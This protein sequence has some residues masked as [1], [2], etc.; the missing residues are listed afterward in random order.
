M[1]WVHGLMAAILV[2]SAGLQLND[3]DPVVWVA[4]YAAAALLAALAATGR[5]PAWRRPVALVV[6]FVALGWALS[7]AFS[8]P[9]VPPLGELVGDWR[10]Y[11]SG[12]EERRETL[13]LLWI[14]CWS[15]LVALPARRGVTRAVY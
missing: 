7:V 15:A 3:P 1:R 13:G 2:L 10:M 9:R 5:R 6:A 4:I 11:A 14:A 12:V 8:S